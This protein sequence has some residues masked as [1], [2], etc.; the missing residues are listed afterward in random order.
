MFVPRWLTTPARPQGA[1]FKSFCPSPKR[2]KCVPPRSKLM[3]AEATGATPKTNTAVAHLSSIRFITSTP[4]GPH[5][6]RALYLQT[7]QPATAATTPRKLRTRLSA[8]GML[9]LVPTAPLVCCG[10]QSSA[11]DTTAAPFIGP[12][13]TA[14]TAPA[15]FPGRWSPRKSSA[16]AESRCSPQY[17]PSHCPD[18]IARRPWHL[19]TLTPHNAANECGC[20]GTSSRCEGC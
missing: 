19:H 12:D 3:C 11:A 15:P 13:T 6:R 20:H 4:V 9:L 10:G 8:F 18:S 16:K 2:D 17:E 5:S 7:P 1:S 14:T